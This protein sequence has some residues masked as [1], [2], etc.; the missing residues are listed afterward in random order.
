[1]NSNLKLSRNWR[2]KDLPSLRQRAGLNQIDLC[3]LSGVSE[4]TLR[5]AETGQTV[6]LNTA[7]KIFNALNNYPHYNGQLDADALLESIPAQE[8]EQNFE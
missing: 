7:S 2:I 4:S 3:E 6:K 8:S 1:M 5:R